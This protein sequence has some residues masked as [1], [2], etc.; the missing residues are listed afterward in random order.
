MAQ[1]MYRKRKEDTI[2]NLQY[3]V[4]ELESGIEQLSQSFLAF[5]DL[6]LETDLL[7]QYSHVAS[8]LH[9]ITQ[10]YVSLARAADEEPLAKAAGVTPAIVNRDEGWNNT[11]S[12]VPSIE[13]DSTMLSSTPIE[14]PNLPLLFTQPPSY[15]GRA[16]QPMGVAMAP[17]AIEYS[18]V[19]SPLHSHSPTIS[20]THSV[21]EERWTFSQ[22]LVKACCQNG[23][24]L[25]VN[26]P[27]DVVKIQGVFGSSVPP[28]E[29]SSLISCFQAGMK[30]ETGDLIDL[31][32]HIPAPLRSKRKYCAPD[33]PANLPKS[34]E[35]TVASEPGEWLDA[36]GVQKVLS[37]RGFSIQENGS[38]FSSSRL[39][40][41]L[42]VATFVQ[43]ECST[44]QDVM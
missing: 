3:R 43:R 37:E 22:N 24:Q 9:T 1:Q 21:K 35:L 32:A 2:G 15:Q 42:H 6:L 31:M 40:S 16:T 30:D 34:W 4:Q 18:I 36:S 11:Y 29:R 44:S 12:S 28:K 7:G 27:N 25:L 26:T 17:P 20:L 8:A 33:E 10:Q 41:S 5:S 14:L 19:P 38:S 23:Y 13:V 39:M